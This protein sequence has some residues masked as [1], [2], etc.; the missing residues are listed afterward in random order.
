[1]EEKTYLDERR[2]LIDAENDQARS[3]DKAIL[4]LSGAGLALSLTFVNDLAPEH[5]RDFLT[6]LYIGW[7][8]FI[9]SMLF[10]LISFQT[11][12]SALRV[13][14][15]DLDLIYSKQEG[16]HFK[17]KFAVWTN[18]LNVISLALFVIGGISIVCFVATNLQ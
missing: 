6:L 11:S 7:G 3:F 17:N 15:D 18:A 10:T 4:T 16:H 5:T 9:S 14:R 13:H 1:M 2:A 8:C 12:Q